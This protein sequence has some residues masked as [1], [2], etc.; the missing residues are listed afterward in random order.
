MRS[1]ALRIVAP[2]APGLRAR[3]TGA[4]YQGGHF[5]LDAHVEAAPEVPL[6]LS[7]PEPCS[8]APGAVIDL[9]IDDG[10][11]IPGAAAG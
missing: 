2:G 10:W 11:V 5:R 6:H 3:V 4:T 9:A 7:L 8:V 1:A